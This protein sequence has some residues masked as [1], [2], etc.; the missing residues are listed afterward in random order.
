MM[1]HR[2]KEFSCSWQ[3]TKEIVMQRIQY[4]WHA[5]EFS[6]FTTAPA[7]QESV[8]ICRYINPCMKWL[9]SVLKQCQFLVSAALSERLIQS[10]TLISMK[11][12]G[13]FFFFFLNFLFWL[14]CYQF[15]FTG[16]FTDVIFETVLFLPSYLPPLN[17]G[18][19]KLSKLL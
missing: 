16:L 13:F 9:N 19:T 17:F 12:L 1:C 11:A 7:I 8:T 3:E 14:I 10:F 5:S 4:R 6:G 15:A 18:K 2:Q